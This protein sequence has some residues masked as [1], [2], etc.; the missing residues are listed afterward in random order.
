MSAFYGKYRGVVTDNLDPESLGR[1]RAKV[2]DVTGDKESGWALPSAPS[3]GFFAVPK[4]GAGVWMEFE[5]GN[6]EQPIWSGCWFGSKLDV[7][8]K[9]LLP[10][11]PSNKTMI[12]TQGGN[13]VLLDDTPAT[14]GITLETK[15]GAKIVI[16]DTGIEIDNG[17]GG[18][19][20]LQGPNVSINQGALQV[21]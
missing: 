8:P 13:S 19:I 6:P 15:T 14:G 1:V 4:V 2:P 16:N 10:A 18:S 11:G 20:K 17:K 5:H 3:S 9:L 7:P 21:I 12:V